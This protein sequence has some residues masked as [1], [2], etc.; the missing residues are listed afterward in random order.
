MSVNITHSH[1]WDFCGFT[2]HSNL[3]LGAHLQNSVL[4]T[5]DENGVLCKLCV[6][7][8]QPQLDHRRVRSL[9]LTAV[10]SA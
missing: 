7:T 6:S 2:P 1:I 9:T 5:F 3:F 4:L 8:I 10:E